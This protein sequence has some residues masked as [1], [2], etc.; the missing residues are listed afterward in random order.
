[1]TLYKVR[2]RTVEAMQ[3]TDHN[4]AEVAKWCDG[5]VS[6]GWRQGDAVLLQGQFA[7]SGDFIVRTGTTNRF[8]VVAPS[9]FHATYEPVID[10]RV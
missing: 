6:T 2:P 5:Y 7:W 4:T 1:M 9:D 3:V 8:E 10:L